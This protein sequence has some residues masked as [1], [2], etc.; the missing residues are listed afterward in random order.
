[1]WFDWFARLSGVA[2]NSF[3]ASRSTPLSIKSATIAPVAVTGREMEGC[4]IAG[5][6]HGTVRAVGDQGP[7][8]RSVALADREQERRVVVRVPGID[9]GALG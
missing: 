4:P 8:Q 1:M 5:V 2:P 6:L 9:L 3:L 7:R